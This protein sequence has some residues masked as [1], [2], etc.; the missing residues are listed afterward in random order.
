M[1]DYKG[2]RAAREGVAWSDRSDRVRLEIG[3][4]DRAKFLHN[5]TTNDI[6]RLPLNRGC[7][8][9]VTSTQGKALAFVKILACPESFL[10][11]TD[12]GGMVLA[13]PHFQKYGIFDDIVLE[14]R[15]E[16]TFEFHLVGPSTAELIR[17]SGGQLP[18][19]GELAHVATTM[20]ECPLLL[21]R[22]SPTGRPGLTLIGARSSAAKV[23]ALLRSQ[24]H[25]LGLTELELETFEV[26]RIEA[27]TPVFGRDVTEK[28][29][30]Q[31]I[32][33]DEQAINFVKGCYLG[34]ETVARLDALGHVN[35][36]LR[37]LLLRHHACV[38]APGSVLEAEGKRVGFVTS[39]ARSPGW[40]APIALA[41]VRTSHAR[42]GAVLIVKQHEQIGA[43]EQMATVCDL[44]ML[45]QNGRTPP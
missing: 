21:I 4:P 32:G 43:K 12:P 45:P 31:E 33:R 24:G 7:E 44:P 25:D 26:L 42:A 36:V 35:Q 39:S 16:T 37:G 5:L 41:M 34:Q 8:A 13:L 23:Y 10:V 38:P 18:A 11:C 1:L 22:E 27:G 9:F 17:R 40:D 20:A 19:P 14:E 30:P 15:S 2:Y 6:K 3:G 29:L 28:N